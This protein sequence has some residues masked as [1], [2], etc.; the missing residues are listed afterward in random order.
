MDT[1]SN[2]DNIMLAFSEGKVQSTHFQDG[3]LN[4]S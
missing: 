2:V 3:L 4:G 1:E